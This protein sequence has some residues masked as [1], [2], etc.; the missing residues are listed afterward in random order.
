MQKRCQLS[1][2]F[3]PGIPNGSFQLY[4]KRGLERGYKAETYK[5]L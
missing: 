1:E 4:R 5:P 3:K 2:S